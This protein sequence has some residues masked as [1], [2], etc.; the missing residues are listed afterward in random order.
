MAAASTA[1]I[2]GATGLGAATSFVAASAHDFAGVAST[3]NPSSGHVGDSLNDTAHLQE[4]VSS[5]RT[6]RFELFGPN[7]DCEDLGKPVFTNDVPAPNDG[8]DDQSAGTD[9]VSTTHSY[10]ATKLGTYQWVVTIIDP[11]KDHERT[12]RCGDEPVTITLGQP[13]L[14][15]N[16]SGGGAVG[17][18]SLVDVATVTGGYF[19]G[20]LNAHVTFSVYGP[21]ASAGDINADSCT[22]ANLVTTLSEAVA[23]GGATQTHASFTSPHFAPATAGVYEWVAQYSGNSNNVA[24]NA[25]CGDAHESDPVTQAQAVVTTPPVTAG[26]GVLGLSITNAPNTGADLTLR[27]ALALIVSGIG[28]IAM[29]AFVGRRRTTS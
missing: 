11:E 5:D 4:N 2:I 3:P 1:A 22:K 24:V 25:K 20:A 16:A 15:T 13:S 9:D 28:F 12:S 19:P 27:T 18:A 10:T 26:G 17:T 14:S 21:F 23:D 8:K 6:I 7:P 29:A